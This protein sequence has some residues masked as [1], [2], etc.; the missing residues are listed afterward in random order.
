MCAL[1]NGKSLRAGAAPQGDFSDGRGWSGSPD[2]TALAVG[3]RTQPSDHL[4][5]KV[6]R[7]ARSSLPSSSHWLRKTRTLLCTA[8]KPDE[9]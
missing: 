1:S 3:R 5:N 2:I 8:T 4:S 9:L 6:T 7:A